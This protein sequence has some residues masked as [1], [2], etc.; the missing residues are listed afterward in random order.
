MSE[1]TAFKLSNLSFAYL[2]RFS[3]FMTFSLYLYGEAEREITVGLYEGEGSENRPFR[4]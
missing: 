3:H 2:H 1:G 4:I